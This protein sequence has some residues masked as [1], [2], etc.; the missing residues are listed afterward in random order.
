M[1]LFVKLLLAHLLGDFVLQPHSWVVSKEQQKL[2]AWQL[3]AHAAIHGICSL[4]LI[5]DISYWAL[6]LWIVL[7][8][9]FIDILKLYA[10]RNNSKV[11]W[12]VV[13]Q[14]LHLI[15]LVILAYAWGGI[16]AGKFDFVSGANIWVYLTAVIFL[17][18]AMPIIMRVLLQKWS[19]NI[20]LTGDDS[21]GNAGKY[22]GI[23]ERL[24]VFVF[25]IVGHWEAV[26][27]LITA[28]SVF[29]FSDLKEA[30]DRKL[31]EYILI[32]TLLSFGIAIITALMAQLAIVLW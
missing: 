24:L 2:K 8:H 13:D 11:I 23:L 30:K 14:L 5:W 9:A 10:Q 22:I 18:A 15:S 3:Y 16:D 7:M 12:F 26:G 17:S 4:L 20:G 28:K 31:T 19:V 21:L 1:I 25:I 6:G 29:R 27:F 32:G